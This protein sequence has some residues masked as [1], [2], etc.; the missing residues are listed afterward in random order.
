MKVTHNLV[1]Q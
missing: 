1:R